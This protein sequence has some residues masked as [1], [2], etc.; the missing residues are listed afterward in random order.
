MAKTRAET[1]ADADGRPGT[2]VMMPNPRAQPQRAALGLTV[3]NETRV[4]AEGLVKIIA[5]VWPA[6][7]LNDSSRV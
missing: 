2:L 1:R 3:S 4:R 7:G 6:N 5:I